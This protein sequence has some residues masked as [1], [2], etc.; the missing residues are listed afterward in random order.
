MIKYSSKLVLAIVQ[1]NSSWALIT[2]LDAFYQQDSS[3]DDCAL[4]RNADMDKNAKV[5]ILQKTEG[6]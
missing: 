3:L 4:P 6:P 2:H 1:S 5:I